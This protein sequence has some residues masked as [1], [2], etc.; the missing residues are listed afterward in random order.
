MHIPTVL[1]QDGR[2]VERRPRRATLGRKSYDVTKLLLSPVLRRIGLPF[3]G[4]SNQGSSGLTLICA[5]GQQSARLLQRRAGRQTVVVM[6]GQPRYDD[7]VAASLHART[8]GRGRLVSMFTTPFIATGLGQDSQLA[9]EALAADLQR[10]IL[11][12]GGTFILKAHPRESRDR[13]VQLVG[14]DAVAQ[15]D[16]LPHEILAM[17]SAAILGMSTVIEEAGILMCPVLVPGFVLHARR[18]DAHLPPSDTYPRFESPIE[19]VKILR[20]IW[21]DD[22]RTLAAKQNEAVQE[23]VT[24]SPERPAAAAVAKAIEGVLRRPSL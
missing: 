18:F 2:L 1:L 22:A 24:F 12:E 15:S 19:A 17:S 11:A 5:T 3:L 9:Q 7:I 14:R 10:A 20:S 13:Y 8:L 21:S 6:T 4:A 16:A 23:W